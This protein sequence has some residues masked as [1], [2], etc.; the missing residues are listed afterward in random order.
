MA[1]AEAFTQSGTLL[2]ASFMPLKNTDNPAAGTATLTPAQVATLTAAYGL[3]EKQSGLLPPS[4]LI[5]FAHVATG[6]DILT[7]VGLVY[8]SEAEAKDA[9][10]KFPGQFSKAPSIIMRG[11]LFQDRFQSYQAT[12]DPTTVYASASAG[13]FVMLFG[14]R[15]P[16]EGPEIVSNGAP[17]TSGL[18][19]RAL[20]NAYIQ[21]DT[22]WLAQQAAAK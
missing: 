14:I 17:R 12:F 22:L 9:A 13:K 3:D 5:G 11:K 16:I 4:R 15:T 6:K 21:R 20:I 1:L 19:Y 10:A 8:D 7:Y 2:Q 18:A